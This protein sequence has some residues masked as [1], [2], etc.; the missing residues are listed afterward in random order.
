MA[1]KSSKALHL[2]PF[3][4]P[5]KDCHRRSGLW[6]CRYCTL[7]VRQGN[8]CN[9]VRFNIYRPLRSRGR[10]LLPSPAAWF[11][12]HRRYVCRGR[13]D[14]G[15]CCLRSES[16]GDKLANLH[17]G[18]MEN[19]ASQVWISPELGVYLM[20]RLDSGELKIAEVA[21]RIG[22][23]KEFTAFVASMGFT[24]KSKVCSHSSATVL[25]V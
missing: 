7:T 13:S 24:L 1:Y 12:R 11:R 21:S 6:R 17:P 4:L 10:H 15:C 14:R 5:R 19:P 16:Y 3:P 2:C 18:G 20:F 9:F 22:D 25:K 8:E 23:I